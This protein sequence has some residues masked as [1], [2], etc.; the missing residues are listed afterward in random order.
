MKP[1]VR[2]R[3]SVWDW[4]ADLEC[5][6]TV[7]HKGNRRPRRK[8]CPKCEIAAKIVQA[9]RKHPE[10]FERFKEEE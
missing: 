6:H 4:W 3:P 7:A 1:V 9:K 5:G 10:L 8:R 2:F